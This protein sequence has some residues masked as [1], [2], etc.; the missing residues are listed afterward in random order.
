[1]AAAA[2]GSKDIQVF[3]WLQFEA[4]KMRNAE[5]SRPIT[6]L[7]MSAFDVTPQAD[8][9][10]FFIGAIDGSKTEKNMTQ[11]IEAI[12]GLAKN[13]GQAR[14]ARAMIEALEEGLGHKVGYKRLLDALLQ[15]EEENE[16]LQGK[17]TQQ[18][19]DATTVQQL[20]RVSVL[21]KRSATEDPKLRKMYAQA[22]RVKEDALFKAGRANSAPL[23]AS[24]Q[25]ALQELYSE[26]AKMEKGKEPAAAGEAA[27]SRLDANRFSG[28]GT[29]T[30]TAAQ[31]AASDRAAAST[32]SIRYSRWCRR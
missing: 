17:Y 9:K 2:A 3:V 10:N 16:V 31:K 27:L 5:I 30:P 14:A 13:P 25:A 23:D 24:T 7:D 11:D 32:R 15:G 8:W 6:A 1:M 4:H 29:S 12:L 19:L 21:V 20:T 28:N 22:I 18:I 26:L